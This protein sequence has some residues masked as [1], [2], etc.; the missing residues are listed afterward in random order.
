MNTTQRNQ[1]KLVIKELDNWRN[2]FINQRE[3]EVSK[4]NYFNVS[5]NKHI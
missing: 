4:K 5:D 3:K 2:N 1:I